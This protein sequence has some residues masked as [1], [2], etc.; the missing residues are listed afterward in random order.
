ML[1][2]NKRR[3]LPLLLLGGISNSLSTKFPSK[4]A[5]DVETPG[6]YRVGADSELTN[7]PDNQHYGF[8][9]V[10]GGMEANI[11]QMQVLMNETGIWFRRRTSQGYNAGWKTVALSS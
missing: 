5:N 1:L 11:Y 6:L 10:F 2:H 3:Q 7:F 4:N 9:I 8:L